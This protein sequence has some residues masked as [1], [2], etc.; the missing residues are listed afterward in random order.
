MPFFFFFLHDY[1]S[2]PQPEHFVSW[3]GCHNHELGA[4]TKAKQIVDKRR[5]SLTAVI[6]LKSTPGARNSFFLLF[7]FKVLSYW[8]PGTTC[9][10]RL[11]CYPLRSQEL[12]KLAS[13]FAEVL[14]VPTVMA[15][16][17]AVSRPCAVTVER[18][19]RLWAAAGVFAEIRE[20][21]EKTGEKR[22]EKHKH[23]SRANIN[24]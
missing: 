10:T 13:A 12:E 8:S 14:E 6:S 17:A 15:R 1:V 2:W 11:P 23:V 21:S 22:A 20:A 9:F 4:K 5:V 24:G 19:P 16:S 7:F 3:T 18:S